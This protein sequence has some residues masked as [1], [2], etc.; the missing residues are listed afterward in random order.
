MKLSLKPK[1]ARVRD[2]KDAWWYDERGG[3]QILVDV[4]GR[5]P[6]RVYIKRSALTRYLVRSTPTPS[7]PGGSA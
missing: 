5:T 7:Q 3:I 6:A 1:S 2:A 4:G